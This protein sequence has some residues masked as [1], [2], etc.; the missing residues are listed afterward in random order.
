MRRRSL[1]NTVAN[2]VPPS[3]V[4]SLD[5]HVA[6]MWVLEVSIFALILAI[7][8]DGLTIK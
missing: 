3:V 4:D 5:L 8:N 7:S 1:R 6:G 2:G